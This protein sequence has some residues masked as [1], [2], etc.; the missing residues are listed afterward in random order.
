M[1]RPK[2]LKDKKP[3]KRRGKDT[4][5]IRVELEKKPLVMSLLK[6]SLDWWRKIVEKNEKID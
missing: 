3:R 6:N 5:H 2:G 1:G 4:T